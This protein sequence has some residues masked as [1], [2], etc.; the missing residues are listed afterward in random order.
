[1]GHI[2]P[3]Q[4]QLVTVSRPLAVPY[5]NIPT[6]A[7]KGTIFHTKTYPSGGKASKSDA[8]A[9]MTSVQ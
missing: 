1:M 6:V 9:L 3:S 2:T 4:A 5:S 8:S 7:K